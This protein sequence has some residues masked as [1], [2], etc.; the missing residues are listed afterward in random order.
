MVRASGIRT[1]GTRIPAR[2][3]R[4][5]PAQLEIES[6][7][8]A[9]ETSLLQ[10]T[11]LAIKQAGIAVKAESFRLASAD[12][13]GIRA[14]EETSACKLKD[15]VDELNQ[16][17]RFLAERIET[18]SARLLG[19]ALGVTVERGRESAIPNLDAA[20]RCYG[21]LSHSY[22]DLMEIR[23]HFRA[24][25]I[26]RNNAKVFPMAVCANLLDQ[27]EEKALAVIG[28]VR[29]RASGIPASVIFDHREAA[30]LAAQLT[31]VKGSRV[32]RIQGFLARAET[33]ASRSL[34]QLACFTL[35]TC[36]APDQP[37]V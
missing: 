14:Q 33:V 26:V 4:R 10:F 34:S 20:W 32:E 37:E 24:A 27:M 7:N 25:L 6:Y 18:T 3:A 36:P 13:A 22:D 2:A 31:V 9:V 1:A 35:S 15:M 17:A 8:L 5:L 29:E 11:A 19:G 12:L 30:T 16:H 28:R 21:A 23:R